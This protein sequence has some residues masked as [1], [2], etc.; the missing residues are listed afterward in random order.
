[1]HNVQETK[2]CFKTNWR[3][4]VCYFYFCYFGRIWIRILVQAIDTLWRIA[5]KTYFRKNFILVNKSLCEVLTRCHLS[6]FVL[7]DFYQVILLLHIFSVIFVWWKSN[8]TQ[9]SYLHV[10]FRT[11][12]PRFTKS[13]LF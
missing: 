2:S 3:L 6:V 11:S 5:S 7:Y 13:I 4:S 12:E 9:L 10:V 1:M 8:N